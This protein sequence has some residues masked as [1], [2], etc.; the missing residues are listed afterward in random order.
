MLS[1]AAQALGSPSMTYI[2]FLS[3]HLWHKSTENPLK[4]YGEII[5]GTTMELVSCDNK[6]LPKDHDISK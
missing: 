5:K 3:P 1:A 2:S 6:L 4:N